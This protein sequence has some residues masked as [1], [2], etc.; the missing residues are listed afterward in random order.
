MTNYNIIYQNVLHKGFVY[1]DFE[2]KN[3]VI[4]LTLSLQASG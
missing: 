1:D 2:T 3:G 4:P